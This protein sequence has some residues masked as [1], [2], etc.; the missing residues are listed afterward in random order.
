MIAVLGHILSDPNPITYLNSLF[1]QVDDGSGG[2]SSA[3]SE[4]PRSAL[5]RRY[6]ATHDGRR[7][8][9]MQSHKHLDWHLEKIVQ[10]RAE[11]WRIYAL[12]YRAFGDVRYRRASPRETK[13]RPGRE[14]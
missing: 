9:I 12:L 3:L 6:L 10:M 2:G 1:D 14:N 13:A 8:G 5:E 11:S 4:P 7:G